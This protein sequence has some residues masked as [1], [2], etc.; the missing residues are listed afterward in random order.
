MSE[1]EVTIEKKKRTPR[2]YWVLIPAPTPVNGGQTFELHVCAGKTAVRKLLEAMEIDATDQRLGGIKVLRADEIPFN[3]KAQT[4]F[5]FGKATDD[6]SEGE[7]EG[8]EI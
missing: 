8:E 1:V 7:S 4:V 2:P 6:E 5:K 3:W